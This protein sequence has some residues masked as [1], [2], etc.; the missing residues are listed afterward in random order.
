MA[1]CGDKQLIFDGAVA[2]TSS[3]QEVTVVNFAAGEKKNTLGFTY[4]IDG[5]A[6]D[7]IKKNS[8]YKIEIRQKVGASASDSDPVLFTQTIR[9]GAA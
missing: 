5:T 8:Q 6:Y 2:T 4:A 7:Q 9:K 1:L 3:D